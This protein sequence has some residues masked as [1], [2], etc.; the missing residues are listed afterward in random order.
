MKKAWWILFLLVG[1]VLYGYYGATPQIEDEP[2]KPSAY[3]QSDFFDFGSVEQGDIL[4]H[5]FLL[6]NKGEV[7]LE[8]KRIATSCSCTSASVAEETV[9]PGKATA[10]KVVYDT[11]AMSG[12]HGRGQQDRI[13]FIKT[14]DPIHSQIEANITAY[15]K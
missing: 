14:N 8:I 13:I 11:G 9:L 10:V 4:E 6:K 2:S 3:F 5:T 7:P 1:L 15:V 12:P